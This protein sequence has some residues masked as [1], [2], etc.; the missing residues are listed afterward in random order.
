MV[1]NIPS[2]YI[3]NENNVLTNGLKCGT[4]CLFKFNFQEQS[5]SF[6]ACTMD[7]GASSN[8]LGLPCIKLSNEFLSNTNNPGMIS[9]NFQND[10]FW[11]D[12][13][14]ITKPGN[15]YIFMDYINSIYPSPGLKTSTD[16]SSSSLLIVCK[17]NHADSYLVIQQ[18]IITRPTAPSNSGGSE[19][20]N[21]INA[22]ANSETSNSS[23]NDVVCGQTAIPLSKVN[24]NNLIPISKQFY[25]YSQQNGVNFNHFIIFSGLNPIIISDSVHQHIK[26]F[27]NNYT[28]KI[29]NIVSI[30]GTATSDRKVFLS[31]QKPVNNLSE[32]EDNIYIQCQPTDQEGNVLVSGQSVAPQT[33]PF[34]L[35]DVMGDNK[36]MFTAAIMG[37]VIMIII[38]KGGEFLLKNGTRT[39][40]GSL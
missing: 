32:G 3:L 28:N 38:V 34:N 40:L 21:I 4:E 6:Q 10:N 24:I 15:D 31:S 36:S 16:I 11:F 30:P 35:N 37:I 12:S 26:D 33:D 7:G 19:I 39:F 29:T 23:F 5:T 18:N 2:K 20:S 1:Y 8:N 17:N 14:Y 13:I 9:V 27:L 25:Y 22:I